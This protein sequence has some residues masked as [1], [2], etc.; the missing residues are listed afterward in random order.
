MKLKAI[1][2]GGDDA[3]KIASFL[4]EKNVPVILT[5]IFQLPSREDDPYDV[6]YEA[7]AKL[8]QAG[9][10]FRNFDRRSWG[11]SAQP[12]L[13]AGMASAFG[14]SKPIALKAVTL[15]PAQILN[16]GDRLGLSRSAK[17]LTSS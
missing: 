13:Y 11:R 4:K 1:I 7:P 15:Y 12:A 3:W 17:W 5:G 8:Q 16:V 14:L 10:R 9:V 2:V 6:M